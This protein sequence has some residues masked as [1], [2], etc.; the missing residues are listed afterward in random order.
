MMVP[1]STIKGRA[2]EIFNLS[3]SGHTASLL[4]YDV[5]CEHL[6]KAPGDETTSF[7][8]LLSCGGIL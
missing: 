7:I 2:V 1:K 8:V 6:L 3:I 4:V 5:G